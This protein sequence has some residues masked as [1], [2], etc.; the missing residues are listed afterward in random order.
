MVLLVLLISASRPIN[1]A[2]TLETKDMDTPP[3]SYLFR[4]DLE[5][6]PKALRLVP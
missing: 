6:N 1:I 3:L 2:E 5:L 4:T